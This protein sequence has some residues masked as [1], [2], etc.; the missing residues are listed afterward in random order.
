[1]GSYSFFTKPHFMRSFK[2]FGLLALAA[3][4]TTAP[5]QA[6][7]P[8]PPKVSVA[9]QDFLAP[10]DLVVVACPVQVATVLLSP[11]ALVH[12]LATVQPE[13]AAPTVMPATR[14]KRPPK[15]PYSLSEALLD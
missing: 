5:A 14:Q 8:D 2:L 6:S 3:M 1:M 13:W 4:L 10:A 9:D 12:E 15:A 7:R 11:P